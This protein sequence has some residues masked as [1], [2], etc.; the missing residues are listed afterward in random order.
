MSGA[1]LKTV[2]EILGHSDYE[3]TMIYAHLADE[4]IKKS[5]NNLPSVVPEL[6]RTLG[7]KP[8]QKKKAVISH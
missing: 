3:T 7:T 6:R 2:G 5:V 8:S 4:H 1:D